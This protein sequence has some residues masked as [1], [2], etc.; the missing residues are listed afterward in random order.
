M[1]SGAEKKGQVYQ[2]CPGNV[3]ALLQHG[4]DEC[5]AD[6]IAIVKVDAIAL[7]RAHERGG[8]VPVPFAADVH[9]NGAGAVHVKLQVEPHAIACRGCRP[10][11]QGGATSGEIKPRAVA[12]DDLARQI[13][14]LGVETLESRKLFFDGG[15]QRASALL[16]RT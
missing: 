4:V 16:D 8:L 15:D 6:E 11:V 10:A 1:N 5:E 2:Y 12:G 13:R 14:R 7:N 3:G 9:I